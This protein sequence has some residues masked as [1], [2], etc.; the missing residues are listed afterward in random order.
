MPKKTSKTGAGGHMG[1]GW[2]CL[3][4]YYSEKNQ[5]TFLQKMCRH[6]EVEEREIDNSCSGFDSQRVII[7]QTAENKR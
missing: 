5:G 1:T 7:C 4:K 6:F 3:W 2:G